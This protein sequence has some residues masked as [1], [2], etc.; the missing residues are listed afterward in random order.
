MNLAN[1]ITVFRICLVPI[2]FTALVSYKP[3]EESY[4]WV[5]LIVFIIASLSDALD[6]YL[7]RVTETRTELG[8]FL[9][10]LADKLLL[11]SAYIGL[12]FVA[13]LPYRP[14]LWIT[15]LIVFRDIII[16]LGLV[17]VYFIKGKVTIAPNFLGKCTT[18]MQ[19]VT[20]I[21]ILLKWNF[22]PFFWYP[23]AVLTILSF[24]VY[25]FREIKGIES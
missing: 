16:I 15:V 7:A 9:D 13:A 6:G 18:A 10:P 21:V 2:F 17:I 1:Q 20:L 8:K 11:A 23:T 3:G 25:S 14:P 24:A 19:M 12:L 5:A 22:A 4:R